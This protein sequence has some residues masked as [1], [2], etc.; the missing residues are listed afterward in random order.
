MFAEFAPAKINLTLRVIRKREDGY[1]ELESLVVFARPRDRLRFVQGGEFSLSCT[2]PTAA[3]A[4]DE[5]SNLVLKAAKLLKDE[6]PQLAAGRFDLWKTLP[7]AAGVGG[8]SSDAAAALR[9]LLRANRLKLDDERV[10]KAARGTGADVPVCL[11]P[12][13]RIMRGI[14][15]ILSQPL[16]L[17]PLP[18]IL[19]NPRVAVPT[20]PIFK[21]LAANRAASGAKSHRGCDAS[22]LVE[23]N[24][25]LSAAAL[26]DAL[27]GSGNDLQEPAIQ[28]QPV[29]ADVIAALRALPGCKLARMSGSGAT[30][31]ALF[32]REDAARAAK[33]LR[34]K[35]PG[36]WV[37]ATVLGAG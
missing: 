31:F 5:I 7:V 26:I 33:A 32:E 25:S 14:G 2:G 10:I 11:D 18:A 1:H 20:G 29:V 35:Q 21:A 34:A 37:K 23:K 30:C 15:E 24:A 27:S 36:W 3:L 17:P 8:G 28:I 16:A 6:I 19:V 4:G 9:C 22:T 12:R 13:P